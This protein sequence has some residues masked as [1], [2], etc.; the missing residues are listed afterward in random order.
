MRKREFLRD[1]GLMETV[2]LLDVLHLLSLDLQLVVLLSDELV[3]QKRSCS[4]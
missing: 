4:V 1:R 3:V 2:E